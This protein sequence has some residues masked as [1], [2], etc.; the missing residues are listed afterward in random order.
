MDWLIDLI[1]QMAGDPRNNS[2]PDPAGVN[3]LNNR[4]ADQFR[5]MYTDPMFYD[6]QRTTNQMNR[7]A[8]PAEAP[9][10]TTIEEILGRR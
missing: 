7:Q 4:N 10:L 8:V 1:A 9:P 5:R 3:P 6:N 2:G